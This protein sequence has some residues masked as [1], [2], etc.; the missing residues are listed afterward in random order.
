[1][2]EWELTQGAA[3]YESERSKTQTLQKH[4]D[5]VMQILEVAMDLQRP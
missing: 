5:I 3:L 4:R 1:M 2:F